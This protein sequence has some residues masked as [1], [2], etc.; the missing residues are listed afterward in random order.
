[1][2]AGRGGGAGGALVAIGAAGAVSTGGTGGTAVGDGIRWRIYSRP[3]VAPDGQRLGWLQVAQS[4]NPVQDVL[5]TLLR[6]TLLGLPLV[7]LLAAVGGLL[8]A[9]RALLPIER[10]TRTAQ[11]VS[12][13]DLTQ[14]IDYRGPADEVGQL[15]TTFDGMLDRLE[16]AFDRERRFTADAS[17]ELRTPLTALKGRIEVTRSRLR[18]PAEYDRALEEMGH[19][20]ERLIRLANDLL[21][22]SRLEQTRS[23]L[24]LH[25]LDLSDLLETLGEQTGPMLAAHT[26]AFTMDIAPDLLIDGDVD[27]LTR[28]FLNL[29]DNAGKYTPTG[30]QVTL[31]GYCDGAGVYVAVSD[32]GPGIPADALPHLFERFYRVEADRSRETG[33]AGLGLAIAYEIARSHRGT[34][35]AENRPTGGALFAVHLPA[36]HQATPP[37]PIPQPSVAPTTAVSPR[38]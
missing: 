1:M 6:Q 23:R 15:A 29:L 17:H 30:G 22:L 32:T 12:A 18:S 5:E 7:L 36:G 31:L 37:A 11:A 16:T 2:P 4:L 13:R 8:L 24:Q 27:H 38:E 19:E 25:P 33:G 10:V 9:R 35:T 26:I 21:F 28:L 3:I 34:V 14:R 20:L